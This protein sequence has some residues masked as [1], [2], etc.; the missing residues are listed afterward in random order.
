MA[1]VQYSVDGIASRL[2]TIL[3]SLGGDLKSLV[4]EMSRTEDHLWSLGV[5]R[6]NI[7]TYMDAMLASLA[8]VRTQI[9]TQLTAIELTSTNYEPPW[10]WEAST[11]CVKFSTG[12]TI[13]AYTNE[14]GSTG[15]TN[16]W[17]GLANGDKISVAGSVSND[18][19]YTVSG[20]LG[21]DGGGTANKITVTETVAANET[22]LKSSDVNKTFKITVIERAVA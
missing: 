8:A 15:S 13:I 17:D 22:L 4:R 14:G 10:G 2:T 16:P 1:T 3:S 9:T 6:D 11:L 21:D 7:E 20:A 18:G 19:N 5:T 12:K